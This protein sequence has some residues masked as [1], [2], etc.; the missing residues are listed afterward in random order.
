MH[1]RKAKI[2]CVLGNFK[3]P[4]CDDALDSPSPGKERPSASLLQRT[5]PAAAASNN[6][7][8]TNVRIPV[9][10]IRTEIGNSY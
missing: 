3:D 6:S 9:K 10:F 7:R 2:L 1:H 4:P 8:Y 5:Y